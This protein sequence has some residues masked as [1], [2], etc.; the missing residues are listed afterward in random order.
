MRYRP[1]SLISPTYKTHFLAESTGFPSQ[2]VFDLYKGREPKSAVRGNKV[3]QRQLW[4]TGAHSSL[5]L[6]EASSEL[7]L[8]ITITKLKH[9]VRDRRGCDAHTQK[10]RDLLGRGRKISPCRGALLYGG[11]AECPAGH[12]RKRSTQESR[13]AC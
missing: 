9:R 1:L 8:P 13:Y 2:W 12:D 4:L 6:C 11:A 5:V 7:E 3:P 10:A